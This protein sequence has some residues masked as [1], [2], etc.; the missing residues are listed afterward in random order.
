MLYQL[1]HRN[2][3]V[4]ELSIDDDGY[5]ADLLSVSCIRH[6][7]PGTVYD[8]EADLDDLR[9]WWKKRSIPATRKGIRQFLESA[10][11]ADT[12]CLLTKCR[13]LSLSDQYWVRDDPATRW[14]DVDFF[15]HPFSPDIGDLLFGAPAGGELDMSSP[16]STTDG[17]LRKR[18][19]VIDGDRCLVKSGT[20]WDQEPFNEVIATILMD[21]QGID[22]A[23]YELMWVDDRPCSVCRDFVTPDTELVTARQMVEAFVPTVNGSYR[24]EYVRVC[25]ELGIDVKP[26]LND[27]DLIDAVI[28]NT[29]RHH[30]NYGVLRDAETLE[31]IRPA[32]IYDSGTS[33]MCRVLTEMIGETLQ[34]AND[35][36][37]I[38]EE[39]AARWRDRFEP[40]RML[41]AL[42]AIGKM[43]HSGVDRSDGVAISHI[44]ADLMVSMIE[45]RI[46]RIDRLANH[47]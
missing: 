21:S 16:D 24:D 29:D 5:I 15:R 46:E 28:I 18:W 42:P 32:P 47:S 25:T 26:V 22:N 2:R 17:V 38:S 31:W 8:G 37:A 7:P 45:S 4:A 43:L 20:F 44:R 35:N 23:G 34:K 36:L 12:R 13:G 1:M 39:L 33:L 11:I 14:E 3:P 6:M 40:E 19:T 27:M 10:D 30:G 41:D 9:N